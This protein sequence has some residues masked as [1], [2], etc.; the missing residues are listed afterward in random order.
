MKIEIKNN[1]NMYN[2]LSINETHLSKASEEL[3]Q[4]HSYSHAVFVE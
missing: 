3:R 1:E 2:E 4:P